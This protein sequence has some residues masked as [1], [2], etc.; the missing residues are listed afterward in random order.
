M[1]PPPLMPWLT[2]DARKR[3][4]IMRALAANYPGEVIKHADWN[5]PDVLLAMWGWGLEQQRLVKQHPGPSLI[6]DYGFF[7]RSAQESHYCRF[8]I[9]GPFP[10]HMPSAPADRFAALGVELQSLGDPDG[11]FIIIGMGRKARRSWDLHTMSWEIKTAR[12]IRKRWPGREII[13]RP[14]RPCGEHIPGCETRPGPL[15]IADAIAG[16]ALVL[17]QHSNVGVDCAVAGVAC[18]TE[19][20]LAGNFSPPTLSTYI[21]SLK[22]RRLFCERLAWWQWHTDEITSGDCWTWILKQV[23]N[24]KS[25]TGGPS[26]NSINISASE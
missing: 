21:P 2:A 11:P 1:N 5:R 19:G 3:R 25:A 12:L 23:A 8:G 24:L 4:Y 7:N 13:Y 26:P 18:S 6:L 14:K 17:C 9:N 16:T 15:A 20:G 10:P 22:K